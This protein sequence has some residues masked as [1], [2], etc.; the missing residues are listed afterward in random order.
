MTRL[1]TRLGLELPLLQAGMGAVAGPALCAEVSRAGAGGTLALYKEA[2]A[3]AARLVREVAAATGRP[4]GVN[5][6]PEVTGPAGCLDQ[7][8]A[9]L[10]E[11][12]RGGFVTSFGLPDAD[13]AQAVRAAGHPLVVQ[14]GTLEDADTALGQGAAVLVLQ[15]TEA[16]GHL[17][18]RLPADVLL[19]AVRARHPHAVLAVAGGIATGEDLAEAVARGADGA[20]AGTLFVPAAESTAHPEFKRRV[21]EAVADDTLITSLFDIGWPNRPHRVLRNALTSASDRAPATFIATTRVDGR[22]HP[23]PRYGAAAPSEATTGHIEQMAMYCGR[24]CTRVTAL[25]PAAVTVARV[26]L[27]YESARRPPT[28]SRQPHRIQER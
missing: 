16:G 17:L 8:R 19:A 27:E 2:P 20:M 10:P 7:L 6:V 14:V 26:R 21:V 5:V 1:S 15:G 12:P 11:L 24:S 28:D 22:E 23:V 9:V 25:H 18:G 4:F 3:R 13:A